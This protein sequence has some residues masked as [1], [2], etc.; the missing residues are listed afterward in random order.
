MATAEQYHAAARFVLAK[1]EQRREI[2][3]L[4][5]RACRYRRR[6]FLLGES[7]CVNPLVTLAG[8][9]ADHRGSEQYIIKCDTQRST[10]SP[11][12]PVMCG[13]QGTLFE[14]K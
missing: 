1:A 10:S 8:K 6:E 9:T 5:C 13:P 4:P 14:P 12:G 7:Y 2:I 3:D 11:W